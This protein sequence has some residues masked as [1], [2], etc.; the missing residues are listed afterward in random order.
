M[1]E[2]RNYLDLKNIPL[3]YQS[4]LFKYVSRVKEN[5]NDELLSVI[6][7]GS[8][9]RKNWSINSD[10]D[11]LLIFSNEITNISALD[12]KLTDLT[13]EFYE[14]NELKDEKGKKIYPPIQ[15][16][17]LSLMDLNKFR[18]LFYDIATD[19]IILFDK[20][21]IG[22]IFIRKIKQRIK[23]K[24]LKRIYLGKNNFY[25]KRKKIKFGEIVEL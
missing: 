15:K 14:N 20:D 12:K 11:L 6:L 21:D 3:F 22:L 7:F 8:L 9:A 1:K 18:T 17:A 16:V 24:G 10:I 4:Y 2:K 25:W 19:G 23:E 13:I 5:F